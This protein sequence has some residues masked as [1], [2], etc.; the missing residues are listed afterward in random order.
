MVDPFLP[1]G[2]WW[3]AN[4]D[5]NVFFLPVFSLDRAQNIYVP[6]VFW[7]VAQIQFSPHFDSN[8]I[9]IL[10]GHSSIIRIVFNHFPTGRIPPLIYFS[11]Y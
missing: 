1:F 5:Q 11:W 9:I 3:T 7:Q 6:T 8:K 2:V 4:F 10:F